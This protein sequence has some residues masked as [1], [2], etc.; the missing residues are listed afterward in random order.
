MPEPAPDGPVG[1]PGDHAEDEAAAD[2]P[3]PDRPDGRRD[4]LRGALLVA[5]IAVPLVV[6]VAALARPRWYPVLDLA[7]TEL[8]LR[9]VGTGHTPLIGLP[10]RIGTFA[11]EQGSHPGPLSFWLLA[12][13][14]RLFGSSAW[15]MFPA[16][17]VLHLGAVVVAAVLARRRGGAPLMLAVLAVTAVLVAGFGPDVLTQPWN[18]YIPLLWWFVV[19]LATW[20]VLCGDLPALV[21]VVFAGSLAAQTHVPYAGL[22]AGM[23][24]LALAG[25][26]HVLWAR[27]GGEDRAGFRRGLWWVAGAVVLGVALWTA[28][29]VDHLTVEPS[30]LSLLVDHFSEPTEATAGPTKAVELVLLH[31]DPLRF[32][33]G[34]DATTGSSGSPPTEIVEGSV[35]PGVVVGLLWL[36]AVV[37]AVRLRH[38]ELVRLHVVVAA[39]LALATLSISRIFGQLWPYLMVWAWCIT[40]LLVLATGWTAWEVLRT[41]RAADGRVTPPR[42]GAVAAVAVVVV[43]AA[44]STVDATSTDVPARP[45]SRTVAAVVPDTVAALDQEDVEGRGHDER[46]LVTWADTLYIGSQGIA[47]LDELERAGF[48]VG[49]E[50]AWGPPVTRHRVRDRSEATSFV[51]LANGPYVDLLRSDPGT[52]EVASF[53][54]RDDAGRA[55][56]AQLTTEVRAEL[57]AAGRDD[58]VPL[59]ET[60]LFAVAIDHEIPDG[61]RDKVHE[62]L[63][64]GLPTSV[65]VGTADPTG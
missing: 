17:V 42:L 18:P 31:L 57:A 48:D 44:V 11:S 4:L 41:R 25:A 8:R 27:R 10:G 22:V 13:T 60:N 21:V 5:V 49:A 16:T 37:A 28:P 52:T 35:I 45:L 20:S 39:G 24:L 61:T 51:Q 30:N 12:P 29:V 19:M 3:H 65:F 53:D 47:L 63:D 40:G 58:L 54:P 43:A 46:Y 50:E 15:A 2:G 38:R 55:R 64:L 14:Y 34:R 26:A 6:A 56:Y 59:V 1:G 7:M 33:G 32:L 23:G 36:A 9:D 62:M